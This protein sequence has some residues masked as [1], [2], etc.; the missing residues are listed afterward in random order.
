MPQDIDLTKSPTIG[1]T[2]GYTSGHSIKPG[3]QLTMGDIHGNAYMLFHLLVENGVLTPLNPGNHDDNSTTLRTI[4]NKTDNNDKQ[5]YHKWK[6]TLKQYRVNPCQLTLIGDILC[7]RGTSD[8][9][10]HALLVYL[11]N[12]SDQNDTTAKQQHEDASTGLSLRCI[13]GNHECKVFAASAPQSETGRA[14]YR[15][16]YNDPFKESFQDE[17]KKKFIAETFSLM[18]AEVG[19]F[20]EINIY[21][22]APMSWSAIESLGHKSDILKQG[23]SLADTIKDKKSNNSEQDSRSILCNIINKISAHYNQSDNLKRQLEA[24]KGQLN[25]TSDQQKPN[26][27]KNISPQFRKQ[28]PVYAIT[29]ERRID[30]LSKD[31]NEI[32]IANNLIKHLPENC[33]VTIYHGHVGPKGNK[34]IR[35]LGTTTFNNLDCSNLGKAPRATSTKQPKI[36]YR[37]D[38]I[39]SIPKEDQ[40]DKINNNR[41][42]E[43]NKISVPDNSWSIS[44]FKADREITLNDYVADLRKRNRNSKADA[45]SNGINAYVHHED[46]TSLIDALGQDYNENRYFNESVFRVRKHSDN[47][48]THRS[49]YFKSEL[50]RMSQN[51]PLSLNR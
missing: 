50:E 12:P 21:T 16:H 5:D 22:H 35:R 40:L 32:E 27:G 38:L 51:S 17:K 49:A 39:Q 18:H 14:Q 44:L 25:S 23:K 10:M 36:Y 30:R 6:R 19:C 26:S 34:N 11:K 37:N 31:P 9:L 20:G 42:D 15:S 13:L 4:Y 46:A 48:S 43:I 24:E 29:M 8:A 45:I 28:C 33:A 2:I 1:R 47:A 41:L 3:Q 7:D